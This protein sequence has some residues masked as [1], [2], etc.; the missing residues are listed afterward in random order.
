[1]KLRHF[2]RDWIIDNKTL[3]YLSLLYLFVC[4]HT[5]ICKIKGV[6]TLFISIPR[7]VEGLIYRYIQQFLRLFYFYKHPLRELMDTLIC[8]ANEVSIIFSKTTSVYPFIRIGYANQV[9]CPGN[10]KSHPETNT[11]Y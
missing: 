6:G 3:T 11:R 7:A 5:S 9:S 1:M 10:L 4:H 8:I 2:H